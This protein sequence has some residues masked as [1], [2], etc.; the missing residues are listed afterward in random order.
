MSE[1]IVVRGPGKGSTVAL[2]PE[3]SVTIGAAIDAA[4]RVGGEGIAGE[5]VAVKAL[6]GGGFGAGASA[7]HAAAHAR[8]APAAAAQAR[9]KDG[10]PGRLSPAH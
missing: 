6:K 1:L 3:R 8:H 9:A 4:I 7:A 10:R 2:S 5:H